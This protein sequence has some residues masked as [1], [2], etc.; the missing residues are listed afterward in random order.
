MEPTWTTPKGNT[1]RM[2]VREGTNDWNICQSIIA[3]D[4][5]KI[6]PDL[7]GVAVDIGAHIGAA[8]V[9]LLADNPD[10]HVV[11]VEPVP[12]NVALLRENT[13]PYAD[14]VTIIE[15]GAGN[16]PQTVRYN[17]RGGQTELIHRFIANQYF[18]PDTECDEI[19]VP[20][21]TLSEIVKD[22]GPIA[23]LKIDCEGCE[24]T[25]LDDPAIEQVAQVAGEYH[26]GAKV[27]VRFDKPKRKPVAKPRKRAP[28][29]RAA[30]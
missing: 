11:A 13:A 18:A 2:Q 7:S 15:G 8:T 22:H 26:T 23:F 28:R 9:R 1:V 25:F 4:E 10:L 14:R 17:W 16:G 20:G 6:P 19:T 21:V 29:K 27:E 5:Y 24:D 3:E 30:K 12:E